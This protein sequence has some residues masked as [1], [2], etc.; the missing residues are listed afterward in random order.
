MK[1]SNLLGILRDYVISYR[2]VRC[3]TPPSPSHL[4]HEMWTKSC[5]S[6]SDNFLLSN[7]NHFLSPSSLF[8]SPNPPI[9][10]SS[11]THI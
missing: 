1:F 11:P 10:S 9:S 5:S 6:Q 3:D 2:G 4:W 8:D 7:S